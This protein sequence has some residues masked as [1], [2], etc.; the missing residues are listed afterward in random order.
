MTQQQT[1]LA[2]ASIRSRLAEAAVNLCRALIGGS[3]GYRPEQ[4]YMRGPGPKWQAKRAAS[5]NAP[6][7]APKAER[8]Y[9]RY[10]LSWRDDDDLPFAH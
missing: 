5:T 9:S 8:F 1:R 2:L 3:H 6:K 4:H 10:D 7:I